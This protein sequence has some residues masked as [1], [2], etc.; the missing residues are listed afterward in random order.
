MHR[1]THEVSI[2]SFVANELLLPTPKEEISGM[3]MKQEDAHFMS[4]QLNLFNTFLYMVLFT[5]NPENG[6]TIICTKFVSYMCHINHLQVNGF[7]QKLM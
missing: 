2:Q 6:R 7:G 4:I 3:L 5:S 1:L